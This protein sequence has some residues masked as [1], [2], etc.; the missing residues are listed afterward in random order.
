MTTSDA[1]RVPKAPFN[2]TLVDRQPNDLMVSWKHDGIR[3][4][5]QACYTSPVTPQ[6]PECNRNIDGLLANFTGLTCAGVEYNISIT[7]WSNGTSSGPTSA[8]FRTS[9]Y[10]ST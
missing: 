5:Y 1:Q 3:D 7:A 2:L 6:L 4:F 9:K 8:M 10:N